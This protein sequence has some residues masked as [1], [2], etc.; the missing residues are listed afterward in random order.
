MRCFDRVGAAIR[1]RLQ[2]ELSNLLRNFP[3]V[4]LVLF[5]RESTLPDI[6][7]PVLGLLAPSYEELL[8]VEHLVLGQ[9][10]AFV[11]ARMPKTLRSR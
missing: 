5:S 4:Q 8:D 11:T 3:L 9:R 2:S 7:L 10:A 1:P 6:D